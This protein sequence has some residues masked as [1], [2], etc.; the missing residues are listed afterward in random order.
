MIFLGSSD[1]S[2][3]GTADLFWFQD[4]DCVNGVVVMNDSNNQDRKS[5]VNNHNSKRL[6]NNNV[7]RKPPPLLIHS[8]ALSKLNSSTT[9]TPLCERKIKAE[10]KFLNQEVRIYA[11]GKWNNNDS[12]RGD[13]PR[14]WCEKCG[15]IYS[16]RNNLQ[17]H[18]RYECGTDH[19]AFKCPYCPHSS[20]RKDN[21]KTHIVKKHNPNYAG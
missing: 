17:R 19:S 13:P 15:R 7:E 4:L 2:A 5:A 20:R 14:Y 18:C 21:L 11:D 8:A 9:I 1:G 10:P 6:T 12:D 16:N 3:F